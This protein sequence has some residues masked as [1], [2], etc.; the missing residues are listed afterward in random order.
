MAIIH[1]W[2]SAHLLHTQYIG[3]VSGDELVQGALDIS[4]DPR[5]ASNDSRT[6]NVDA[7]ADALEARL[8][9][10]TSAAWIEIL[11]EAGVPCGPLNDVAAVLADPQIAARYMVVRLEDPVAGTL[12]LAGN[13]IKL[14]AFPDPT[15]RSPAPELDADRSRILSELEAPDPGSDAGLPRY[16]DVVAARRVVARHLPR[17]PLHTYP[18]LSSLVGAEVWVKHENHHALGAFKVRGGVNLASGLTPEQRAAGLYTAS[19]GNHGQ[20]IAFAG[21]VT[22]T[23]VTVAVPE[24]AN[25]MKVA[26][27]RALGAEVI[28]HGADFDVAREW[29]A[30][31][32]RE[33]GARFVGPTD[34]ELIAGVGTY[35]LEIFEALPDADVILVPVGSGSGAA[36]VCIVAKTLRPKT[37]VIAVQ[38]EKAPAAYLAWKHGK[39]VPATMETRAEAVATRVPF[40]NTQRLLRDPE[41]G[42]D[43]FVLVSDEAMAEGVRLLL[44]HSHNLAEFGGA[45]PLAA[46][47]AIKQRLENQK[48]VLV[49]SGGN[50]APEGLARVMAREIY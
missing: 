49:L 30:E 21:K 42:L 32:A 10:R 12:Q 18:G 23:S 19:T 26:S 46:A 13:P 15:T 3:Q 7:L 8:G 35:T 17:T 5:F 27:M 36:A 43:D 20:S 6:A 1:N 14:S 34:P 9:E 40:D 24:G 28:E 16:L 45:A 37:R 44:E 41:R 38:A 29:I 48:V 33:R 39:T 25:P 31:R 47:L 2:E 50:L 11:R 22:G 4:G